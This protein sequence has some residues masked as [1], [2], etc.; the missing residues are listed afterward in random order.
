MLN[1]TT[2]TTT[3]T[4]ANLKEYKNIKGF[5]EEYLQKTVDHYLFESFDFLYRS[6]FIKR[7]SAMKFACRT[8]AYSEDLVQADFNVVS[9]NM[10]RSYFTRNSGL[11]RHYSSTPTHAMNTMS[12]AKHKLRDIFFYYTDLLHHSG[13]KNK[14]RNLVLNVNSKEQRLNM[15]RLMNLLRPINKQVF[16]SLTMQP[17]YNFLLPTN[18]NRRPRRKIVNIRVFRLGI[19]FKIKKFTRRPW[20]RLP[21]RTWRTRRERRKKLR[22]IRHRKFKIIDKIK[23]TLRKPIK[24]N[25][26]KSL[27]KNLVLRNRILNLLSH[28]RRSG[29]FKR[30]L[31]RRRLFGSFRN[32]RRRKSQRK[33]SRLITFRTRH[34]TFRTRISF[35]KHFFFLK[36]KLRRQRK[37]HRKQIKPKSPIKFSAVSKIKLRYNRIN[38][39]NRIN[40]IKHKLGLQKLKKTKRVGQII[41]LSTSYRHTLRLW[42]NNLR[43]WKKLRRRWRVL[44]RRWRHLRLWHKLRTQRYFLLLH[45]WKRRRFIRIKHSWINPDRKLLRKRNKRNKFIKFNKRNKRNNIRSKRY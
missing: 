6:R 23:K 17:K 20:K 25:A 4:T 37:L 40:T 2:M 12:R 41:Q 39:I 10:L 22:R 31:R 45:L 9:Y 1:T 28:K 26:Q 24:R 35:I 15:P 42:Q 30:I 43:L 11:M 18:R 38:G 32:V 29:F 21:Q 14:Y 3:M 8:I 36:A 19:P 33:R 27:K 5:R 44:L 7:N 13:A 16:F 34:K